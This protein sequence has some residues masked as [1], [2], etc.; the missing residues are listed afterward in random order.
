MC[1]DADR[2]FREDWNCARA[3]L[4]PFLLKGA[5]ARDNTSPGVF[6][7]GRRQ[8]DSDPD[9]EFA[10]SREAQDFIAEAM[11]LRCRA[12][13]LYAEK[14]LERLYEIAM[15]DERGA[16]QVSASR[17][18]LEQVLGRAMPAA[19]VPARQDEDSRAAIAAI[20]ARLREKLDRVTESGGPATPEG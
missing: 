8:M 11:R 5:S 7:S 12:Q 20:G 4:P 3:A 18:L 15:K 2:C 9:S 1:R 6:V 16:V 10:A 13:I 14:L 19:D 17:E